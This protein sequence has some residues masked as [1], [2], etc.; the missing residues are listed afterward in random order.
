MIEILN[1]Y[2]VQHKSINVPGL[3]TIYIERIPANTD[4]INKQVFPPQYKYGFDKNLD[5]PDNDLFIFLAQQKNIPG[6]EATQSYNQ[7][8]GS[9]QT[10]IN[11]DNMAEW[12]DVGVFRKLPSGDIIFE[13][14]VSAGRLFGPVPAER[15]VRNNAAHSILV[16]DREKTNIEMTG[17]LNEQKNVQKSN[18]K[19]V[20][21]SAQKN[22]QKTPQINVQESAQINVQESARVNVQ[23]VEQ[24]NVVIPAQRPRQTWWIFALVL[25]IIAV[26]ILAYHFSTHGFTWKSIANQEKFELVTP[27]SR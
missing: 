17:L 4:F 2:L 11:E 22:V 5:T 14:V 27:H 9:L 3:G 12:Q 13:P 6:D 19:R 16:G 21:K 24:A 15:V 20:Q 25:F 18:Q 10:K 23:E 8:A 7:F 26:S 1:R